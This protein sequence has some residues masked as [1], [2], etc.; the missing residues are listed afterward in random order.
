MKNFKI[1]KEGLVKKISEI[2]PYSTEIYKNVDDMAC[3][4]LFYEVF[5]DIAKYNTTTKTWFVFTG[6]RWEKDEGNMY[7]EALAKSLTAAWIRSASESEDTSTDYLRYQNKI[8]GLRQRT[9]RDKMILDARSFNCVDFKSFDAKD[10]LINL[11]NGTFNLDTMKLQ[12]HDSKDMISK[13]ANVSYD[14]D[15]YSEE[16]YSFINE[17][18]QND[19]EKID[20]L[21][22]IFGYCLSATTEQEE[23]YILYGKST[24]NGKSTLLETIADLLNDYAAN[25]PS[26]SFAQMKRDSRAASGDIARLENVRM[27]HMTEPDKRMIFDV[28]LLKRV[29]GADTLTARKL[30][31]S[32]IEFRPK[33]KLIM[34]TNHLPMVNDETLFKSNRIKVITFDRHF[35]EYEQDKDLKSRLQ[36]PDNASGIFNWLLEG[37]H[38]YKKKG[39]EAPDSV[40]KAT[41]QYKNESDKIGLFIED[42]LI[43]IEYSIIAGCKVYESYKKWCFENGYKEESI[44]RFYRELRNRDM[45]ED[46]G[47]INGK[48]VRRVIKGYSLITNNKNDINY[49]EYEPE[50][51]PW[52]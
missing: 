26:E 30:Y 29:T 7:V 50:S 36:S 38:K 42:C 43:E 23:C 20:Y 24:R 15:S 13:I 35:E 22:R 45:L 12:E 17:V 47:T 9:K 33:F 10:N 6:K 32:E 19:K 31:E 8:N 28:A 21:Q 39:L 3:G 37:Y 51:L 11:Q 25:V 14:Q 44:N 48:T 27:V 41:N 40:I 18:M 49:M 46:S 16:F 2:N 52:Q 1:N 34:N 5:K 4:K